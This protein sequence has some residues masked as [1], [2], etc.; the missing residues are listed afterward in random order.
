MGTDR[1]TGCSNEAFLC[2]SRTEIQSSSL[3]GNRN[4]VIPQEHWQAITQAENW[5]AVLIQP[6][7]YFTQVIF[8]K[9]A[10]L[11]VCI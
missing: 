11:E 3:Q 5:M 8:I 6:Y 9:P 1:D 2:L 4:S 10:K 7:P